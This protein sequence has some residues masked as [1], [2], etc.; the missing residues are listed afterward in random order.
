M[1]DF[2]A[3]RCHQVGKAS[4]PATSG[5]QLINHVWKLE[6]QARTLWQKLVQFLYL[7]TPQTSSPRLVTRSMKGRL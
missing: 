3:Q 1:K 4:M 6:R 5:F 2:V 7:V